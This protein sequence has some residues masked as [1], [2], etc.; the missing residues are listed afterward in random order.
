MIHVGEQEMRG[1]HFGRDTGT[2]T[3]MREKVPERV[4]PSS[5][6]TTTIAKQCMIAFDVHAGTAKGAE[7]IG[8]EDVDAQAALEFDDKFIRPHSETQDNRR[9]RGKEVT[10][11][12]LGLGEQLCAV[13]VAHTTGG[14]VSLKCIDVQAPR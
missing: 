9:H 11:R 12:R 3:K 4:M 1:L 2:V 5:A 10:C 6:V 14:D 8:R 13:R 7:A